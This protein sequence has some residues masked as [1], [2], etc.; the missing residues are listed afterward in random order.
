MFDLERQL[1]P[2]TATSMVATDSRKLT[3]EERQR[4]VFES[5]RHRVFAVGYYM[6]AN[7]LEAEHILT[8]TFVNAFARNN[9]PDACVVDQA[10]MVELER[11]FSLQ[12]VAAAVPDTERSL[13]RAANRRTDMEEALRLLPPIERLV[14]LLKDVEAYSTPRVAS[15]LDRSERDVQQA[16]FSARI[17]MRNVLASIQAAASGR[18]GAYPAGEEEKGGAVAGA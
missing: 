10:L 4:D 5:H 13:A 7:E 12:S 9:E 14:F 1:S 15:L 8:D 18:E 6:T 16:H 17:R 2:A 3:E 11:R